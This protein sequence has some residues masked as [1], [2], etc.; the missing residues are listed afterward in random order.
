MLTDRAPLEKTVNLVINDRNGD[1]VRCKD[2]YSSSCQL[3]GERDSR[4]PMLEERANLG[5]R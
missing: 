2:S 1:S 4:A 5:Q 3:G